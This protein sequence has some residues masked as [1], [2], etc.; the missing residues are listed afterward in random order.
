MIARLLPDSCDAEGTP[1]RKLGPRHGF[2]PT[3]PMATYL[4]QPLSVRC[5]SLENLRRFLC[6]CSYVSDQK[7]FRVRDYWMPPEEFERRRQGDCD[8]A[9]LWAWRQ[10]LEMGYEARFVLGRASAMGHGHA[11]VMFRDGNGWA[12]LEPF[13]ARGGAELP[14]WDVLFHRPMGSVGWDGERLR[15][16]EHRDV[17]YAPPLPLLVRLLFRAA[18]YRMRNAPLIVRSRWYHLRRFFR[19]GVSGG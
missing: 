10:L 7:Q 16:F 14:Q 15:Y 11:W 18:V 9:S 3:F 19:R 8:C 17:R 5:G 2:R 12:V 4:T 6:G 13:A 1:V